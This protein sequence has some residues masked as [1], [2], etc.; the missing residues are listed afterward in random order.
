MSFIYSLIA[1][2]IN[3]QSQNILW[4]VNTAIVQF[5]FSRANLAISEGED[6]PSQLFILKSGENDQSITFQ[7]RVTPGTARENEGSQ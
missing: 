3:F 7:V 2:T 4:I 5:N 1:I 6:L